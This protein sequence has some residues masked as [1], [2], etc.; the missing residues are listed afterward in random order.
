MKIELSKVSSVYSGKAGKCC[1]GCSGT[2][3]YASK[4]RGE[5]G[6]RRGYPVAADE[7]DDAEIQRVVALM[8]SPRNE[9]NLENGGDYVSLVV[10]KRL[11]VA[12]MRG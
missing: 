3:S 12:Y 10:G 11:Y 7:I 9:G 1:C 8:N 6:N 5:A 2:H 4:H